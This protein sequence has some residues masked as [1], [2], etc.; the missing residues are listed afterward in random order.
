M[1]S[2]ERKPQLPVCSEPHLSCVFLG[3]SIALS[4]PP[5]PPLWS[6]DYTRYFYSLA[7]LSWGP[8]EI[9]TTALHWAITRHWVKH[10]AHINLCSSHNNPIKTCFYCPWCTDEKTKA[11]EGEMP[12]LRYTVG[13]WEHGT[14]I[15]VMMRSY[16]RGI[17][18]TTSPLLPPLQEV[19]RDSCTR[20]TLVLPIGSSTSGF[21]VLWH[22]INVP[23][24][25]LFLYLPPCNRI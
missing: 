2:G 13:S 17:T 14:Q 8:N 7:E 23:L 16:Q 24:W 5:F 19:S 4:V 10:F 20:V 9:I 1:G 15:W 12:A 11:L 25:E 22:P 6:R 3:K 21:Y 18:A